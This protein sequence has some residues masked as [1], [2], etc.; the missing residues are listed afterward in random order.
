MYRDSFWCETICLDALS[1]NATRLKN[2][3]A[4]RFNELRLC[5]AT[6]ITVS[7]IDLSLMDFP[8]YELICAHT[9]EVFCDANFDTR[10]Y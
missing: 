10:R 9:Q 2:D 4:N 3:F 1:V 6:P 8:R 7:H 5:G